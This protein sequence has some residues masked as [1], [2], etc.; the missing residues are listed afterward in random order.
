MIMNVFMGN[1]VT[2]IGFFFSLEI[3]LSITESMDI[4]QTKYI[5][6]YGQYII[7]TL[8]HTYTLQRKY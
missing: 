3:N 7:Y 5:E 6:P 2:W 1:N 8:A 4:N